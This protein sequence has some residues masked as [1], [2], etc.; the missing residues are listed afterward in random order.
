M[1]DV[2][3]IRENLDYVTNAVRSNDPPGGVPA[4]YFLW[5]GLIAVGF[6]LPGLAPRLIPYYWLPASIG[7]GLLSWWMG[8]RAEKRTGVR[9]VALGRRHGFHWLVVGIAFLLSFVPLITG[10]IAPGMGS[11]NFLL[12]AGLGYALAGVHLDRPM[13]YCGLIMLAG[14][15]VMVWLAPPFAWT[16]T[17]LAV[18]ASLL[19]AGLCSRRALHRGEAE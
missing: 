9:N 2:N 8:A 16:L 11:A 15:A 4:I 13:L 5:A 14:Y 12:V 1:N 18:G 10:R 17:G 7:G 3:K 19:V 6:A